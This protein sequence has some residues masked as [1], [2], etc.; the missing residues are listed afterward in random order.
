MHRELVASKGGCQDRR[1]GR[2]GLDL[3]GPRYYR[4]LSVLNFHSNSA[5]WQVRKR[6]L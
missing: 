1:R 4:M 3:A 2:G 6:L 5:S